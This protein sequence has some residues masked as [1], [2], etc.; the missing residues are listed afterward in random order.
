MASEDFKIC[1]GCFQSWKSRE[2]FLSDPSLELNGY[3]PDFKELEFGM[4]LFTH[5]NGR[6]LSTMALLV[7]SFVDLYSGVKY[8]GNKS[9]SD[10]CPRYC[11]DEKQLNRCDAICERAFVREVLEIVKNHEKTC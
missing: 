8:K 6:C 11:I 5:K 9:L 3:K 2:D 7:E 4:F 1:P 10:E